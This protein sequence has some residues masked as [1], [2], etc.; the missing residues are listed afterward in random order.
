MGGCERGPSETKAKGMNGRQ[1]GAGRT[2]RLDS[3]GFVRYEREA[4]IEGEEMADE[5]ESG[6]EKAKRR[7]RKRTVLK[8]RREKGAVCEGSL[9]L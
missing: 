3:A 2:K 8:R 7:K 5:E 6:P 9:R 1:R 4:D